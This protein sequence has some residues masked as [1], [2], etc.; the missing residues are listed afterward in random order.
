M[1]QEERKEVWIARIQDYWSSG[2][3]AATWCERHG[4]TPR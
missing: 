3:R 1:T 2:E 4:V